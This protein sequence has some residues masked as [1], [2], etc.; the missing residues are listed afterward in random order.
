M[1]GNV[2]PYLPHLNEESKIRYNAY[3]C[4]LCKVLGRQN[5]IFSRFLL[6][7]DMV[8]VAMIYDSLNNIRSHINSQGCFANPFKKK[9]VI[10]FTEGT[11]YRADVLVMLAYFKVKDDIRDEDIA[12]KVVY[13][14]ALPYFY[15]KYKAA[16]KRNTQLAQ[17]LREQ[18]KKQSEL[19]KQSSSFDELCMPTANMVK[20]ILNNCT[21]ERDKRAIGQ[22]GFF[23][24]R[25]IYMTDALIDREEDKA[26]GRFNAFNS[27][28]YTDDRAKEEC[29][30]ALGELAHWYNS[31]E[32]KD[33]KEI[34]DN[35][36]YMSMARNIKFAGQEKEQ[37]NGK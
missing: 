1:L 10:S 5:G 22:M 19:E 21:K 31:M 32:L 34:T 13:T 14:A 30:M 35:I 17:V 2:K 26:K 37:E 29:F 11:A 20:A 18:S 36:I 3:Y 16:E 6:N 24:G 28:N 12:K 15:F 23:L 4:G 27:S 7:Y 25:V 8:F 9:S 33:I